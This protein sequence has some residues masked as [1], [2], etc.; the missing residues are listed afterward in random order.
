M[1]K[2]HNLILV[3]LI[4]GLIGFGVVEGILLPQ[5]ELKQQRYEAA[6]RVPAT[7]DL[8][9]IL[10]YKSKYMGDASNIS[11]LF[12]HLPLA[13]VQ[14]TIELQS[15]IRL[16]Q[17]NYP[18]NSKTVDTVRLEQSLAYN[19]IAAFALIDN[20][21]SIVYH[22]EDVDYRAERANVEQLYGDHLNDLLTVDLW[23]ENVQKII[24]N[25]SSFD[26]SQ[27]VGITP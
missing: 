12:Q 9:S 4:M 15:D 16:A 11:N 22:F 23:K 6:Q 7:H 26:Y 1:K 10:P 21:E 14:E 5:R 13:E 3:L 8:Q 18:V 24:A 20:L 27:I 2:R 25:D 19:S 17:I